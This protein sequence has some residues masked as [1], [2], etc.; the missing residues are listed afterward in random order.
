MKTQLFTSTIV[1]STVAGAFNKNIH[2]YAHL[3]LF[4]TRRN[5]ARGEWNFSLFVRYQPKLIKKGQRKILLLAKN[6]AWW[7][8][9]LIQLPRSII[10]NG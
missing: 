2:A 9:G 6:S 4:S 10:V 3:S 1:I 5:F 8:T 7:K